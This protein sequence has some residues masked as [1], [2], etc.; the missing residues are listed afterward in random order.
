MLKQSKKKKA[1]VSVECVY[2]K[3][4]TVLDV[5]AMGNCIHSL[6]NKHAF[7]TVRLTLKLLEL[8]IPPSTQRLYC[9]HCFKM[10]GLKG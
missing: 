2:E 10:G 3:Y 5:F 6:K 4:R 7:Y 1:N 9:L 8:K